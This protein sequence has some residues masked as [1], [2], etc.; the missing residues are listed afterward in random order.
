MASHNK[1]NPLRPRLPEHTAEALISFIEDYAGNMP[2]VIGLSGGL[3]STVVAYLCARALGPERVYAYHMP[4]DSTPEED[5]RH[6]ET[7]AEKLGINYSSVDITPVEEAFFSI[8]PIEDR[9][10]RGNVKA[11][12]RMVLLYSH[13]NLLGGLVAGTSNKS[14]I[15]TGYFTKYGDGASDF[16]PIGDL[17]KTQVRELARILGVPRDIIEKAPRAGLWAGQTDEGEL[18]IE[19]DL[20]DSILHGIELLYPSEKIA[21]LVGV[22][23]ETV[24][25][26]EEMVRRSMHKR[27]LTYIAKIGVRTPGWDWRER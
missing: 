1:E 19:Y 6:A 2:V 26:V 13:A 8:H 18:G 11:R 22:P 5:T 25:R 14:E 10:A 20:L 12:I 15:L 27:T 16:A 24:M 17:Y 9:V 21:E 7:V 23:M 3:D 4:D